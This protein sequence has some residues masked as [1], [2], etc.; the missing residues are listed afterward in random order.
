M[1]G[2]VRSSSE[3]DLDLEED[4]GRIGTACAGDSSEPIFCL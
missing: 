2:F 1:V 4:V 3:G